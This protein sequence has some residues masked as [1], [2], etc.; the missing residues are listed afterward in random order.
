MMTKMAVEAQELE[1]G[2][3][4][5]LHSTQFVVEHVRP[6]ALWGDVISVL[7]NAGFL[8]FKATHKVWTTPTWVKMSD[9]EEPSIV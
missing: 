1:P 7:T 6:A 9:D 8:T 2:D 3:I 4:I 5:Y